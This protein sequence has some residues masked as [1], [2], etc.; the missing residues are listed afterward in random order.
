MT[1]KKIVVQIPCLNEEKGISA[2]V[3]KIKKKIPKCRIIV[4]DNGSDDNSVDVAKK[5]GAEVRFVDKKGKPKKIP[6]EI[7]SKFKPYFCDTIKS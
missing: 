2:V 4:Y 7:Y 6:E 1:K 3:K 5:S